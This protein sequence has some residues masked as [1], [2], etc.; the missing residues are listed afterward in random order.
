MDLNYVIRNLHEK[1]LKKRSW[2]DRQNKKY[3]D[4]WTFGSHNYK[5]KKKQSR[6]NNEKLKLEQL[7]NKDR[8]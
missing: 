4:I 2:T 6:N 8:K 3:E 7:L 5:Y 1:Y